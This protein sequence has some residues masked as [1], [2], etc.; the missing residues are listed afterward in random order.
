MLTRVMVVIISQ[1]LCCT[2]A[3]SREP[4]YPLPD[5]WY[6]GKNNNNTHWLSCSSGHWRS[7]VKVSAGLTPSGCSL[8]RALCYFFR[9]STFL[10]LWPPSSN[11]ITLTSTSCHIFS[12]S[13]IFLLPACDYF[14]PTQI[15]QDNFIH[16]IHSGKKSSK[17]IHLKNLNLIT[18]AKS[19]GKVT[20]FRDYKV[21]VFGK[22]LFS[23]PQEVTPE[24]EW[25]FPGSAKMWKSLKET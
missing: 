22:L 5:F 16:F 10:G 13:L 15:T 9:Q 8:F 11:G 18:S 3:I 25:R 17:I 14:G 6:S 23:L 12:L 24:G 2:P 7:K 21:D 19:L 4:S 20:G 1:S